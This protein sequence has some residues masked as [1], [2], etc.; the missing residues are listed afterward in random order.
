MY[1]LYKKYQNNLKRKQYFFLIE[2]KKE[3][4]I[5]ILIDIQNSDFKKK[6]IELK[7]INF[8]NIR[9]IIKNKYF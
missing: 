5:N 9:I 3:N 4:I 2:K 1:P 6:S 8:L 7:N